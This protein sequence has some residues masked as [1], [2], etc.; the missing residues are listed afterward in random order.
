MNLWPKGLARCAS[1]S[2][3]KSK[4]VNSQDIRKTT[5]GNRR[6]KP[7]GAALNTLAI[8]VALAFGMAPPAAHAQAG[9]QV[10]ID[11][12][13]QSLNRALLQLGQQTDIQL[14]YLP[15]TVQ[16]LNAPAVSGTMTPD[17]ALQ[18][19]LAG[20][21]IEFRTSGKTVTLSRPGSSSSVAQL[22]E[23]T[24]IGAPATGATTEGSGSYAANAVTMFGNAQSL[25]DIPSSVSV[26]TRQQMDDQNITTINNAM[27]YTTGV[28]SIG[29]AGTMGAGTRA[30]YNARGF[31]VDVLLDG[32]S[33]VSGIQWLSQFDM[34]MY[35]RVET[36]R[37]PA[38]LLDGQ[39][40][41]G[42]SVN[43]VRKMPTDTFQIKSETSIGSWANYRQMVDVSGPLNKEGTLRGRV[44]GVASKG[45]SYLDGERSREGMGY[46]VLEYDIDPRTTVSL[47]AGYQTA[48]VYRFDFGVGYDS[49][50]HLVIGP[51]G[52]SQNFGPDWNRSYTTI[53]E[54]NATL[55]HR[56]DNGWNAQATV[57]SHEYDAYYKYAYT[58]T[59]VAGTNTAAYYGQRQDVKDD[60]LGVDAHVSGPVTV[61]GR[62]NDVLLGASYASYNYKF[63]SASQ[64]IG[65]YD[66]F[67]P[68]I[69][70]PDLPYT[71][72]T[73][74]RIEQYSLY[75]QVHAHL[76][77]KFSLVLG[78][79]DVFFRE[80]TRTT[81]PTDT[82]WNTVAKQNGKFV[83]YGGL[84]Y[85][86]TP[87]IS[88]YTS[89]SKIFSA[90]T[91]STYSGAAIQPFTGEQYEVGLK[92][93]FL[94]NR[95]NATIAAF[96]INGDH[97][98]VSDQTHAGYYVDSGAV[99]SQGWEAE[100]SGS[101][102]P[103]WNIVTGYTLANT[104]YLSSPTAQGQSYSGETPQHL[105]KLWTTYRF[106][107]EALQGFSVGGG[108][109]VQSNTWRF[110]PQYHQGGYATFST[111]VGY[112]FNSHV[113]ADVTVNNVFNRKY[114]SR[115]PYTLFAEY[116]APRSVMLTVRASY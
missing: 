33:I 44:V 4:T 64:N 73:R 68:R 36:F 69:P 76:T 78:G 110:K 56:F 75:G 115:A 15:E 58:N 20:T 57:L 88:A 48:P 46:A 38:G 97:L 107:Q 66:I 62:K 45:N 61:L 108:M 35:D 7:V 27:L 102:L 24:V 63:L 79:R 111:K 18:K 16:G 17:Q 98:A 39:G 71:S 19:L 50:N 14:Y 105:F 43:L 65:T 59:P 114:Y 109:Y 10:R 5:A 84:I 23:V 83:P 25:K 22:P 89:Y 55:K 94:D 53:K 81:L 41:F 31:P 54:A 26:L 67:S 11:I 96:R 104:R 86:L 13:A 42:G 37:G 30:Y 82:S 34:A 12:P 21:G 32:Q 74:T 8:S 99:R 80:R 28:S 116:G 51:R 49:A 9:M 103:N 72:G 29:Y 3:D 95:L 112:Q 52:W 70:E 100:L 93:G 113:Q 6:G 91:S 90:Q 87:Q 60:W 101:P 40:S 2:S 106:T 47:S 1:Y 92:G 77:D 85:A